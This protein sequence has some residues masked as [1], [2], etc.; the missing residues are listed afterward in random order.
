VRVAHRPQARDK[1]G[2]RGDVPSLAEDRLEHEAGDLGGRRP[3]PQQQLE[4]LEAVVHAN[5]V[6][7]VREGGDEQPLRRRTLSSVTEGSLL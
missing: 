1:A 3:L 4:L 5:A 2:R 7:L 6:K